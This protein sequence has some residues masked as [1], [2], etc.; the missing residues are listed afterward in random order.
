VGALSEG[1]WAGIDLGSRQVKLAVMQGNRV[2]DKR[3]FD[4]AP[5]Y[6]DHARRANGEL[7]VDFAALEL[8]ELNG[9][10]STGYGR[11]NVRLKGARAV[12]ELK[13]HV[14]GAI[15]QTGL[16][17]FILVDLGGQDS[18][19]IK[20]QSGVVADFLTNDKCAA[21]SGRYL[22]NMAAVLGIPLEELAS[23]SDDPVALD[24]TCAVF[25]E[26]ELIGKISEGHRPPNLAAGVNYTIFRRV[27][28]MLLKFLPGP[29]V[30]TGGVAR[31]PALRRIIQ[32]ELNTEVIVP[33][34]PQ[35]NGATGAALLAAQR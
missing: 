13:A 32:A 25:G 4:T 33:D 17:D 27:R 34:D 35:F 9:V 6:R 23:Y 11:N 10:V 26:S 1:V 21:S 30:F 18:K 16:S 19:V 2:L 5:F 24:A 7:L 12:T 20:V 3:L 14:R 8:P 22:E 29:V 15:Y 31:S 28:P